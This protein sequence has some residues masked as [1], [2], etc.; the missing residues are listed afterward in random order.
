LSNI[1]HES[2]ESEHDFSIVRFNE[3]ELEGKQQLEIK[4]FKGET[5]GERILFFG[6]PFGTQHMTSHVGYISADFWHNRT[7]IF[8]IDGSINPGNSGGPIIHLP[9][10]SVIGIVTR[11]ETG[12]EKDF[13]QLINALKQNIDVLDRSRQSGARISIAG[14]DPI[15]ATKVTLKILAKLSYNIKRSANVGIGFGFSSEHILG[16]GLLKQ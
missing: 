5:V 16:T 9:S 6:F 3:P 14:V 7:H 13:D 10:G 12:L 11:S 15:E 8:Q 2:P 1:I 4:T